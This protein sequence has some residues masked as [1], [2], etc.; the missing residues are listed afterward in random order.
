MAF[1]QSF[2]TLCRKVTEELQNQLSDKNNKEKYVDN[3]QYISDQEI[4][5]AIQELEM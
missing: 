4:I 3:N 2:R 5:D 1:I